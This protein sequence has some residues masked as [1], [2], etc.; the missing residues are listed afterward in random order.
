MPP[1]L[2]SSR[3]GISPV[4]TAV[5]ITAVGITITVAI[6]LWISGLVRSFA[7][8]EKIEADFQGCVLEEGVFKIRTRL[9]N[10]GG[11][12]TQVGSILVNDIPLE[13]V[14]G[15]G[16]SWVSE[17]GE[18]GSRTPIPLKTGVNVNVD[19][20]IPSGTSCGGGTLTSGVTI[21]ISFR[22]TGNVDYKIMVKLP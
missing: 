7:N 8:Y 19:L 3:R 17:N 10:I 4:I 15:T 16:L 11:T 2:L 18:S 14:E 21:T 13:N 9:K 5:I 20:K 22:S 1:L 12:M 6:M